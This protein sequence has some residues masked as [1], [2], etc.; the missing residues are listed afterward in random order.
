MDAARPKGATVYRPFKS[1]FGRL[2][3]LVRTRL[4]LAALA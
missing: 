3:R 1:P 2:L 4:T